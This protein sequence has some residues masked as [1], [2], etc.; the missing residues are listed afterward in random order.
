[1][2]NTYEY[3]SQTFVPQPPFILTP[4]VAKILYFDPLK[5]LWWGI[6]EAGGMNLGMAILGYSLPP[7]DDHARQ[8]IYRLTDNYTRFE[9]DLTIAGVKKLPLRIVNL[10]S[11]EEDIREFR[12]RYGF[13]DWN[14]TETW[15]DG[16]SRESLDFVFAEQP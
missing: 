11:G 15:L 16:F 9:P 3:Y 10:A 7:H 13:V 5:Y 4:S 12:S 6:G 14:R 8:A 1:M 2:K